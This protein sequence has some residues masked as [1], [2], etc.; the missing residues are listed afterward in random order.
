M[1]R[2]NIENTPSI[3]GVH[4][5]ARVFLAA[6]VDGF[7]AGILLADLAELLA[8][9]GHQVRAGVQVLL[10]RLLDVEEILAGNV[11]GLHFAVA[12]N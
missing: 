9:I 6:V 12:L 4:I 11:G 1:P 3:V 2:L 7:V 10:E 8:F 5:P